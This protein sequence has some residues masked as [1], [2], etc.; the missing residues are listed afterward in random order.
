MKRAFGRVVALKPQGYESFFKEHGSFASPTR[1]DIWVDI[2]RVGWFMN[3]VGF[4]VHKRLVSIGFI[5]ELM[6]YGV[7]GQWRTLGPLVHGWRA[8]LN[9]PESFRWFE[10][11]SKELEK[12][13]A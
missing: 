9:T 3:G 8:E 1:S 11:L 10:Y 6:G 5:D 4:M 12:R 2:D 7:I 13:S